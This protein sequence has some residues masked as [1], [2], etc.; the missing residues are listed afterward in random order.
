MEGPDRYDEVRRAALAVRQALSANGAIVI[1]LFDGGMRVSSSTDV[2][3]DEMQ[4]EVNRIFEALKN[5]YPGRVTF[6]GEGTSNTVTGEIVR[7]RFIERRDPD[8]DSDSSD[9]R[10]PPPR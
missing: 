2:G 9:G 10:R 4:R 6:R 3:D 7:A 5:A 8:A 1:C